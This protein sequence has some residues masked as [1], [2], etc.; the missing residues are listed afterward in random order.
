MI[1][2]SISVSDY[3]LLE[4]A[5][6]KSFS[7]QF[8]APIIILIGDNGSGK[9][10]LFKALTPYGQDKSV[11]H[12]TGRVKLELQHEEGHY[13]LGVDYRNK[14]AYF[15]EKDL[16]NLNESGN[17]TDQE[18]LTENIL[19]YSPEL[20]KLLRMEYRMSK[21]TKK[22]RKE[23][24][25][26]FNP[27]DLTMLLEYQKKISSTLRGM[28]SNIKMLSQRRLVLL[29]KAISEEELLTVQNRVADL[30]ADQEDH[31]KAVF[32]VDEKI[33]EVKSQRDQLILNHPELRGFNK[34]RMKQRFFEVINSI[35]ELWLKH[36][37]IYHEYHFLSSDQI[38]GKL[39]RMQQNI[40]SFES[41]ISD[42][43]QR[44]EKY[45]AYQKLDLDREITPRKERLKVI[46]TEMLRLQPKF[47]RADFNIDLVKD[48]LSTILPSIRTALD[49]LIEAQGKILEPKYLENIYNRLTSLSYKV[50]SLNRQKEEHEA[51]IREIDNS[52]SV[53]QSKE[54]F[55]DDCFMTH[56]HLR[57]NIEQKV[58][59]LQ[60]RKNQHVD[61]LKLCISKLAK[62]Q[63]V[64]DKL[65]YIAKKQEFIKPAI[66]YIVNLDK[67]HHLIFEYLCPDGLFSSLNSN[68]SII[69]I[70]LM[71]LRDEF[72][73]ILQLQELSQD[74][75]KIMFELTKLE[76]PNI[77][78]K[79]LIDSVTDTL[80]KELHTAQLKHNNLTRSVIALSN[81]SKVD[82][83]YQQLR[84]EA[85]DL[86]EFHKLW[87][88]YFGYLK[89][90]ELYKHTKEILDGEIT[91]I[92]IQLIT[93]SKLKQEQENIH[94]ILKQEILPTLEDLTEKEKKYTIL[95]Q[96]LSP[97]DGFPKSYL[98]SYLNNII[99]N[100]N[101]I[102]AQTWYDDIRIEPLSMK[103]DIDFTFK[104]RVNGYQASDISCCSTSQKDIIDIVWNIS[105]LVSL[106]YGQNYPIYL[107]EC[108]EHFDE[109]HRERLIGL[110][111]N[112]IKSKQ[113]KQI[114]LINHHAA[115]ST[116]L[117]DSQTICLSS[118]NISVPEKY[119]EHVVIA[120]K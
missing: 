8:T 95:E 83:A 96:T 42:K 104:R 73:N 79:E 11:F 2:K 44:L 24:L 38:D 71:Q 43:I 113:I 51:G 54:S 115:L 52:L 7:A 69:V 80:E 29:D 84:K 68:I 39:N 1:Y 18:S 117:A 20:D 50:N 58:R 85:K 21:M 15:F 63:R 97:S 78:V 48:M 98:I 108:D 82:I 34:E 28:R 19:G 46:E 37:H 103:D 77:P 30:E 107:D 81:L 60:D 53:I 6:I 61:S 3:H 40:S 64:A 56:C 45:K 67:H 9:S 41:E 100:T 74:R 86:T 66:D 49:D 33:R 65:S 10:S 12:K 118:N 13:T 116:G 120:Y 111:S 93:L 99:S 27:Y 25:M 90:L 17:V 4:P 70:K 101:A 31:R 92:N 72:Q 26:F 22:E 109:G 23:F 105:M 76:D 91:D 75:T 88:T 14:Q 114:F 5:G 32:L 36:G 87:V 16:E 59:V 57:S 119:N 94:M 55:P 35:K 62:Y 89:Q 112:L 102:L 47:L 106:G 110:I